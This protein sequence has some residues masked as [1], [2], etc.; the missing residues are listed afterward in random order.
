MWFPRSAPPHPH[1]LRGVGA[2]PTSP[3]GREWVGGKARPPPRQVLS[4]PV[5]GSVA[6]TPRLIEG[7]ELGLE[8]APFDEDD[9]PVDCDC[10]ASCYRGHRGDRSAP[11]AAGDGGW[12]WRPPLPPHLC[13]RPTPPPS[14]PGPSTG[15]AALRR[16]LPRRRRK[17]K[18][19]TGE[20]GESR[21]WAGG[22]GRG[23]VGPPAAHPWAGRALTPRTVGPPH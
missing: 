17:R 14:H 15:L 23:A 4:V 21:P 20:A 9:G 19:A 5:A 10:P 8:Y 18:A 7:A 11:A 3:P 13:P 12:G 16:P 2:I 22:G 1:D 6:E